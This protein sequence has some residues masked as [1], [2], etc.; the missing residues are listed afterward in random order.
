MQGT[1]QPH[2]LPAKHKCHKPQHTTLKL[3]VLIMYKERNTHFNSFCSSI[4][5]QRH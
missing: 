1:S 4:F 3:N 5:L 2:Q